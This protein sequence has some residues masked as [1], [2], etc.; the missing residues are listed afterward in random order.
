VKNSKNLLMMSYLFAYGI[1]IPSLEEKN[2]INID[3]IDMT[4]APKIIPRDAMF[5]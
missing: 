1:N 2:S 3:N 5:L 4:P